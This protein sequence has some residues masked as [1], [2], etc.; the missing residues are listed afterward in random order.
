MTQQEREHDGADEAEPN[1]GAPAP[2]SAH[3]AA[4]QPTP[5]RR[6]AW[7]RAVELLLP[8]VLAGGAMGMH[9]WLN[10]PAKIVHSPKDQGAKDK[11]PDKKK[12]AE[13]KPRP[14]QRNEARTA[15]VLDAE[16]EQYGAAPFEQEP[17]RTAWA[18]R[19]QMVINR[20]FEEARRHAFAGAPEDP[21]VVLASNTCHTVRC[22]F[23]LR[24]SFPHELDLTTTA[25]ERMRESGEPLWRSF[26]VEPVEPPEAKDSK[27]L[28]QHAVQV[29][30]AFRT[31][32]TEVGA[33]EIPP[34]TPAQDGEPEQGGDPE[35][36][37]PEQ[38]G[39]PE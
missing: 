31:D 19:H 32:D 27:S 10:V 17:T 37:E 36:G 16:W 20:A 35:N 38:G 13:R 15:E 30:V 12:E 39:D 14:T 9:W 7:Q 24:S 25:L 6:P 11:K 34:A 23:L 3:E 28:T 2:A 8:V 22:R 33:L 5:S 21:T 18:R 4:A 29:T 26:T 1:E